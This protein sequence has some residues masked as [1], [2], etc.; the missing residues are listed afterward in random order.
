MSTYQERFGKALMSINDYYSISLPFIYYK[1]GK[2]YECLIIYYIKS[3]R[4]K[5]F[6]IILLDS[7][8]KY[9]ILNP[10]DLLT[11]DDITA[12]YSREYI[13]EKNN[14]INLDYI[15]KYEELYEKYISNK[16]CFKNQI[17]MAECLNEFLLYEEIKEIYLKVSPSFFKT[18]LKI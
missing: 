4:M 1:E 7:D 6:K 18:F 10:Q 9:S 11:E 12:I 15:F 16:A 2:E 14:L 5:D 17:A 3:N 13:K 8:E